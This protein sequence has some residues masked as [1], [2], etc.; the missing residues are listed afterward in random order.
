MPAAANPHDRFFR[1]AFAD[2]DLAADFLAHYLPAEAAGQLDPTVLVPDSETFVD[3]ELR[4]AQGDLLLRVGLRGG[5]DAWIYVLIEHKSYPDRM[6]AFQLLRYL[7]RIWERDARRDAGSPAE[8]RPILPIVLYHGRR[9]WRAPTRLGAL[10]AGAELLRPHLP[11]LEVVLV[12]LTARSEAEIVGRVRLRVVLLT[13]R[14]IFRPDLAARLPRILAL[15]A[16]VI[17]QPTAAGTLRVVLRY[18]AQ[19][20]TTITEPELRQA[21]VAALQRGGDESMTTIAEQ[22]VAQGFAKGIEQGLHRGLLQAIELALRERFGGPSPAVDALLRDLGA[23]A[24]AD[25]L[26]AVL[27]AIVAGEPLEG[28]RRVMG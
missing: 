19:A 5:G 10:F 25:V 22:W 1:E 7:V 14:A 16:D 9:P 26:R 18:V 15:L 24:D 13:L 4:G 28:V 23:V 20:G 3:D 11:E 17:H 27:R 8:L 6:V 12:D 2:P 21:V